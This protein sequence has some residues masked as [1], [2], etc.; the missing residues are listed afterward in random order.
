V[1][2]GQTDRQFVRLNN[3]SMRGSVSPQSM[4]E[5]SITDESGEC[6]NGPSAERLDRS[7]S[8]LELQDLW[9]S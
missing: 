3:G 6:G 9:H 5:Q 7:E 2:E 4:Q 1:S 8:G